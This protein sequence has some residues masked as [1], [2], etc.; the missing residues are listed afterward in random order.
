MENHLKILDEAYMKASMGSWT[1][2]VKNRKIELS[3]GFCNIYGINPVNQPSDFEELI[4][5][6]VHP[7]DREYVKEYHKSASHLLGGN[8][9]TYRIIKKNGERRWLEAFP[10]AVGEV[11]NLGNPLWLVGVIR[12]I[13]EKRA[14]EDKLRY[15]QKMDSIGTIAGGIAHDFNN[16]LYAM[17]GYIVLLKSVKINNSEASEYLEQ[18][19][20]ANKRATGLVKQILTFSRSAHIKVTRTSLDTVMSKLI[21]R[22]KSILPAGI[23][24]KTDFVNILQPIVA[25]G[26]L[27]VQSLYNIAENGIWA[28]DKKEGRLTISTS[29]QK[30]QFSKDL[31]CGRILPGG[32][33]QITI[34]DTGKGIDEPTRSRIFEPFFTTRQAGD[35]SGLGLAIAYG[36]LVGMEGGID[37]ISEPGKGTIFK[38]FLPIKGK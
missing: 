33:I 13:T 28:M 11:D 24:L 26:N 14:F 22:I 12:D 23:T 19:E 25:D 8:S 16:I 29:L 1:E 6:F 10:A 34:E 20:L 21:S 3:A 32:Y 37:V 9:Y 18:I 17:A 30:I 4:E 31:D 5:L 36:A 15:A 27:L 7:E 35:G 2:Y 38:I